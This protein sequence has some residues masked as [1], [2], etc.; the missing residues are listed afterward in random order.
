MHVPFREKHLFQLLKLYDQETKPLDFIVMTYFREMKQLGSKDRA[1]INDTAYNLIRWQGLYGYLL[2][3]KASWESCLRLMQ[4]KKPESFL[5]DTSIPLHVRVSFPES[6]FRE[7]CASHGE[8]AAVDICL[9]LNYPA[10]TTVRANAL[11]GTREALLKRFQEKDFQVVVSKQ[12]PCGIQFLKKINFFE[13]QEFR[14]GFFEVQDEASQMAAELVEK[15]LHAQ[16]LDFCAGSGG[17][18][19]ALAPKF[20]GTGQIHLHDIRQKALFEA[21]KRLRRAGIQNA[22][23]LHASEVKKLKNLK[24]RMDIVLVDAPCTG[25]GTLRRNP[26]MKWKYTEEM[27]DRLQAEQRAIFA[28]AFTYLKPGGQ[29]LYMTCSILKKENEDQAAHFLATLPLKEEKRFQSV[30][31]QGEMDGFFAVSFRRDS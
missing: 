31:K 21:R 26:D 20:E 12:A 6:L 4:E 11:K 28:D 22:Q 19:L 2:G 13:L 25:T 23:I 9:A 1:Y 30:P 27:V 5:E 15:K 29:I 14:D 3:S 7:I 17:K 8:K 18:T 16:V 10:P 24:G